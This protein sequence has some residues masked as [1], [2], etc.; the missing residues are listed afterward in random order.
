[1]SVD[2]NKN[3]G[4]KM[5]FESFQAIL[6]NVVFLSVHIPPYPARVWGGGG[7]GGVVIT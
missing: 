3:H 7:G 1:M 6:D 5:H 4:L 2:K